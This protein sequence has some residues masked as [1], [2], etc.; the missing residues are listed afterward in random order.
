MKG[1]LDNV[2]ILRQIK[3]THATYDQFAAV[4]KELTRRALSRLDYIKQ[5]PQC[6]LDLSLQSRDSEPVLRRLYPTAYCVSTSPVI[7]DLP[8]RPWRFFRK[9]QPRVVVPFADLPFQESSIDFIF[10]SLKLLWVNERQRLLQDCYR[11]LKPGGMLLFT[12]LGPDTLS[13]LR[14]AFLAGDQYD[15]VHPFMDMHDIGDM[16]VQ[17]GFQQPVMDVEHV[18]LEYQTLSGLTEDLRKTG[19]TNALIKR[20]RGLMTPRQWKRVE[21]AYPRLAEGAYGATFEWIYGHAWVGQHKQHIQ[22]GKTVFVPL[23]SLER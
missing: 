9:S 22:E 19:S 18:V 17:V 4:Q 7:L 6:I 23:S 10:M 2:Q 8:A 20:E 12:T 5:Q 15:H 14:Q 16:L 13:E 3:A 11:V 21:Q 1:D